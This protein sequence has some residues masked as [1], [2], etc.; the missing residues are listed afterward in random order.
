MA[1]ISLNQSGIATSNQDEVQTIVNLYE[2]ITLDNLQDVTTTA[3]ATGQA[4]IYNSVSG[5]W[6]NRALLTAGTGIV[7]DPATGDISV[8]ISAGGSGVFDRVTINAGGSLLQGNSNRFTPTYSPDITYQLGSGALNFKGLLVDNGGQNTNRSAL[9]MRS[10]SGAG[11]ARAHIIAETARGPATTPARVR[12][13]DKMIEIDGTGYSNAGWITDLA[14]EFPAEISLT[15]AEDFLGSSNCGTGFLVRLQPKATA[16]NSTS[17]KDVLFMSPAVSR[18]KTDVTNFT[19]TS[20]TTGGYAAID[21]KPGNFSGTGSAQE[22]AI[23]VNTISD[24]G[25]SSQAVLATY[26]RSGSNYVPS[27]SGDILGLFKFNGNISTGT[28]PSSPGPAT[29]VAGYATETW[30]VGNNGA[31][32]R[33]QTTPKGSTAGSFVVALDVTAEK[34]SAGTAFKLVTYADAT[35][36]DT[37]IPSPEAGMMIFITGTSKFQGYDGSTW[38]DLN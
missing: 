28:T 5:D 12:N 13:N 8:D 4:L 36:R 17:K 37:A 14:S 9:V 23:T 1:V 18:H 11:G 2:T 25:F 29:Q 10:Y 19:H 30:T 21:V 27:A 32:F 16:L 33:F 6:E 34:V 26:R 20:D 3:P 7:F 22:S 24:S 15:A 38:A 35:A 31:G